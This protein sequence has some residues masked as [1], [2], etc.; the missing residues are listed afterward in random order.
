MLSPEER[1][2]HAD[3]AAVE[4]RSLPARAEHVYPLDFKAEPWLLANQGSIAPR[5]KAAILADLGRAAFL[6]DEMGDGLAD[7]PSPADG[8][9]TGNYA[10]PVPLWCWPEPA[11]SVAKRVGVST[12]DLNWYLEGKRGLSVLAVSRLLELF[13]LEPSEDLRRGDGSLFYEACGNYVLFAPDK[14]KNL[15]RNVRDPHTWGRL[16]VKR[17]GSARK[18]VGRPELALSNGRRLSQYVHRGISA[19]IRCGRGARPGGKRRAAHQLHRS[20][21]SPL[22]TLPGNGSTLCR[23]RRLARSNV[24]TRQFGT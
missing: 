13:G 17:R 5:S 20:V 9:F 23:R 6:A 4:K 3:F 1:Q 14:P 10:V 22:G 8:D 7:M 18:W 12:R 24:R 21:H 15:T 19:R 11:A 2:I 16:Q